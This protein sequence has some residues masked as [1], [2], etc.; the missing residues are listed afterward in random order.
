MAESH[1]VSGDGLG[2]DDTGRET[3]HSKQDFGVFFMFVFPLGRSK[4]KELF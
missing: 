3:G 2:K 4:H 1:N